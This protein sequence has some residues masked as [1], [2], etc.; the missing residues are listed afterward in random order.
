M[1]AQ[2]AH[3]PRIPEIGTLP[4][5]V[6][7][8]LS[9]S[10]KVGPLSEQ[11]RSA[12]DR[13]LR[14]VRSDLR[15]FLAAM[16]LEAQNASGLARAL[17][18]ERTS[19]QRVVAAVTKPYVGLSLVEALPGPKGVLGLLDAAKARGLGPKPSEI[20]A[21]A[22]RVREY[23][24]AVRGLAGSRSKLL[25]RIES[26]GASSTGQ[27]LDGD[28]RTRRALFD[29][30]SAATG[31]HSDLWMAMH[32]YEPIAGRDDILR[33]TRAH[34]LIG[35]RAADDAVPL[36]FHIFA[37][38]ASG[39]DD[40]LTPGVYRALADDAPPG[41]PESLLAS[42]STE[43]TPIVSAKQPDEF[44]VQA[45][46]ASQSSGAAD[47]GVDFV[48]GMTGIMSH[49][50]AFS[51]ELEE[52]WAL[53]NF[54]VRRLILDAYLHRDVASRCIPALDA[55]LW[56]PDFAQNAGERWQ[57]RFPNPPTLQVLGRGSDRA[58]TDAWPRHAELRELIFRSRGL[59]TD[60]FVGYRCDVTYPMWRTGY[61]MSFDFGQG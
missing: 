29:A 42:F 24:R 61:C 17:D 1:P 38:S 34:G 25:K 4:I 58:R 12:L 9:T 32:V 52:I 7:A 23:D 3:A 44:I 5:D 39:D 59:N 43:P 40:E 16:P 28:E 35:H 18:T 2:A 30:S 8:V 37:E 49:P 33:Q 36:T 56:R 47:A 46:E 45:I 21:I 48:F 11:E 53:V 51:P 15:A 50:A 60:D 22:D 19:C 55:H 31:R 14:A 27:T 6:S 10:R 54:P 41:A 57:T 13:T 26:V 20:D